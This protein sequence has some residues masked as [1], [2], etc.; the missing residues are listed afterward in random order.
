MTSKLLQQ[1]E[2]IQRDLNI[3]TLNCPLINKA[4]I[5]GIHPFSLHVEKDNSW[6]SN[7]TML[8]AE[9]LVGRHFWWTAVD[10]K[11]KP[12]LQFT[13]QKQRCSDGNAMVTSKIPINCWWADNANYILLTAKW[14]HLMICMW[15]ESTMSL[16][17]LH[18][19]RH[20]NSHG[21]NDMEQNDNQT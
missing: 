12:K 19:R 20:V 10:S 11:P 2:P 1:V 17:M 16:L 14:A 5:A 6:K 21:C 15:L 4:A 7:F 13:L 8:R 9:E 3:I 18:I